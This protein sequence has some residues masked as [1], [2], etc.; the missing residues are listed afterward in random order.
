MHGPSISPSVTGSRAR[1]RICLTCS[2]YVVYPRPLSLL[3]RCVPVSLCR[4]MSPDAS[5]LTGHDHLSLAV[6]QNADA[7]DQPIGDWDTSSV[8]TMQ[9][10]FWVCAHCQVAVVAGPLDCMDRRSR[11]LIIR[12]FM[13]RADAFNQDLNEWDTSSVTTMEDMFR[14]RVRCLIVCPS[15]SHA[16]MLTSRDH[17]PLV[18][19]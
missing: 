12:L 19:L 17:L 18:V 5:P 1:W 4:R 10:M 3:C 8:T 2:T 11:T 13:Q 15:I 14:V 6:L 7:F 16:S 9:R